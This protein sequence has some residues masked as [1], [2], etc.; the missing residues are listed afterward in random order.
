MA[1]DL[2]LPALDVRFPRHGRASS[3][4]E[5][6]DAGERGI[7]P[8]HLLTAD[9]ASQGRCARL[10]PRPPPVSIHQHASRI[11]DLGKKRRIMLRVAESNEVDGTTDRG[12]KRF[13]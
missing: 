4:K 7:D 3:A 13:A 10:Q 8:A 11:Q 5:A 9:S 2:T 6:I 12:R 1:H